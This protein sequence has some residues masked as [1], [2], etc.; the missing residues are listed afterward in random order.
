VS[1]E[2]FPTFGTDRLAL[3]LYLHVLEGEVGGQLVDGHGKRLGD[4]AV[5]SPGDGFPYRAL[6]FEN[7]DG[8]P[9]DRARA[10]DERTAQLALAAGP[11]G[12]R[13]VI[14]DLYP[15]VENPRWFR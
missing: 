11:Q 13:F 14:R 15:L 9:P 7:L 2:P 5:M 8:R 12:A 6:R 1:V 4:L 3:G 10:Q